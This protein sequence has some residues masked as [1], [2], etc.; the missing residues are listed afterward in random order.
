METLLVIAGVVIL[1]A[2]IVVI[3]SKSRWTTIAT[4]R[5]EQAEELDMQS[6]FLKSHNI[7]SRVEANQS[8]AASGI[9]PGASFTGGAPKSMVFRLEV[10]PKDKARAKA[11]LEQFERERKADESLSL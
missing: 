4:A 9:T 1:V 5:G 8:G 11:L 7:R 10:K 6:A 2:L 3:V